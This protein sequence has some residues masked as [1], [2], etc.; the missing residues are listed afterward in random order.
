MTAS[1]ATRA[2]NVHNICPIVSSIAT[3]SS[4]MKLLVFNFYLH[5][6]V[7]VATFLIFVGYLDATCN[8]L[9][10]ALFNYTYK[11]GLPF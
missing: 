11:I 10:R 2:G 1:S 5:Y 3:S 6:D 9:Y 4:S 7:C 8:V